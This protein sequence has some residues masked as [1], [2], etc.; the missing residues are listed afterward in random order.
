MLIKD[1]LGY[2]TYQF[3]QYIHEIAAIIQNDTQT[4]VLCNLLNKLCNYTDAT[5]KTYPNG[6]Q[7]H[8]YH[9]QK[10]IYTNELF[11]N[12]LK[13]INAIKCLKE[14]GYITTFTAKQPNNQLLDITY[15][16]LNIDKIKEAFAN[17]YRL[18]HKTEPQPMQASKDTKQPTHK[19]NSNASKLS[20]QQQAEL[21]QIENKYKAGF[22]NEET[23][24][25]RKER[26]Q[27]NNN[28]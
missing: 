7:Y 14:K 19:Q 2:D 15:F 26:I 27:N 10:D 11:I 17:G 23:Y 4:L 20:A 6:K 12:K 3:N 16:L 21:I 28:N 18:I 1:I 24:K 8:F 25:M 13:Y 5:V 9:S 22:I